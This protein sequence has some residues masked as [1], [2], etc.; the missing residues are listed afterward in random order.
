MSE[1]VDSTG[2]QRGVFLGFPEH[3]LFFQFADPGDISI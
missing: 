1:Q 2:S 3:E